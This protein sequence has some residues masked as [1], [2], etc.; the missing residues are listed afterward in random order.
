MHNF[1]PPFFSSLDDELAREL[2]SWQVPLDT[3]RNE[4]IGSTKVILNGTCRLNECNLGMTE[5][6]K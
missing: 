5:L 2:E 4:V 1:Q 6:L 3:L